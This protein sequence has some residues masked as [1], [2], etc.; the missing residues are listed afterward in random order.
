MLGIDLSL[1]SAAVALSPGAR[2]AFWDALTAPTLPLWLTLTRATT[3][4][5][6]D[7]SAVMQSAAINAARFDHDPLTG[8]ARGLLVES[9]RANSAKYSQTFLNGAWTKDHS[10]IGVGLTGPDGVAGSAVKLIEDATTGNHQFYQLSVL[11]AGTCAL[12]AIVKAAERTIAYVSAYDGTLTRIAYFDLATGLIAATSNAT[13]PKITPMAQGFFEISAIV[14]PTAAASA[15]VGAAAVSGTQGYAGNGSSGLYAF[16]L[17]A[18]AGGYPTSY[19]PTTSAAAT[20]A[21]DALSLAAGYSGNPIIVETQSEATGAISRTLHNPGSGISALADVWLR[22]AAV[23]RIGT[24]TSV[25][26][27]IVAGGAW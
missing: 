7:A 21:A 12:K 6:F 2:L 27:A 10:S 4:S 3:G 14:A 16:A 18:E 5:Y 1:T 15:S 26:N 22:K 17:Q 23:Y 13:S 8:A 24:P 11:A 19:I 20:R 25:L 9:S